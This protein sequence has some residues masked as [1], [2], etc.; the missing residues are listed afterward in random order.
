MS[1]PKE[2]FD[3]GD[4]SEEGNNILFYI[5][6]WGEK[7]F[8]KRR[9]SELVSED[10]SPPLSRLHTTASGFGLKGL[11]GCYDKVFNLKD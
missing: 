1:D 4:D 9:E 6:Q 11:L 7:V 5:F 3:E 8:V 10:T 2:T